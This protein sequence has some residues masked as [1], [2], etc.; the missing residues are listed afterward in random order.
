MRNC[1][2]E[3][4]QRKSTPYVTYSG[5][6][7]WKETSWEIGIDYEESF[8][9]GEQLNKV[10][11]QLRNKEENIN[12]ITQRFNLNCLFMFVIIMNNGYTPALSLNSEMISFA[13]RINAEIHFDLYANPYESEY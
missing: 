9:T 7:Y 13:H 10:L 1:K 2:G 6:H 3:I 11:A 8:D 12:E 5:T 4:I